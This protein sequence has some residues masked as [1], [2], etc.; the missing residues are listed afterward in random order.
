MPMPWIHPYAHVDPYLS[1]YMYD[2]RARSPSYI[3]SS[4]QYYAAPRRSTF[5]Q[6]HVKDR[7]GHKESVQS[8]MKKKEVVK[9][10]YRVKRDG[11]KS[12]IYDL[13]SN[14]KE[15]IKKLTLANKGDEASQPSAEFEE[16]K[17]RV[18]KD[19]K[20]FPLNE[21]ES[22]TRCPL[23]LSY[24][25]KKKLQ[26]L[27][28]Q[29]LKMRNMEWVPKGGNQKKSDVKDLIATNTTKEKKEKNESVVHL[30]ETVDSDIKIV[31][32]RSRMQPVE[33]KQDQQQKL[34]SHFGSIEFF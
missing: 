24:W 25:Q 32:I 31:S 16:K 15:P 22:Q 33:P 23:D 9:Q 26:K 20:E 28:A 11:R 18:H 17:L 30:F 27:S 7:F 1:W 4:H 5:E 6:S 2:T 12:G 13:I 10:V 3:K 8:T 19:K 14:E 34:Q 21:T 29:E